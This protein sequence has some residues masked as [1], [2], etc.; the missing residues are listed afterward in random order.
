[1]KR[2]ELD[3]PA[4]NMPLVPLLTIADLERILRVDRR[5]IFRLCGA[6]KLPRPVRIGGSRRWK[7]Q[8][9]LRLIGELCD[10]GGRSPRTVE[11]GMTKE[12]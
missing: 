8:D 6:G 12:I 4:A 7:P 3:G 11:R 5:T 2:T 1:M 10:D 9:I